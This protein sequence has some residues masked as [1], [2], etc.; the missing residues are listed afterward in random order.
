MSDDSDQ[1]LVGGR[2]VSD[3]KVVEL[4]KE[5]EIRSLPKSGNKK[6]LVERLEHF[7]REENA[8]QT[9]Q[10][11]QLQQPS[12]TT[13]LKQQ[14]S[15]PSKSPVAVLPPVVA[16]YLAQQQIQL[17][18][19]RRSADQ[20][21]AGTSLTESTI[22]GQISSPTPADIEEQ[23]EEANQE[24][25]QKGSE[26]VL[27]EPIP[28]PVV[29]KA[30][31]VEKL[32]EPEI[33]KG[34]GPMA[35]AVKSVDEIKRD[36]TEKEEASDES[37]SENGVEVAGKEQ[38]EET[39][40]VEKYDE[41]ATEPIQDE[42]EPSSHVEEY[43][44]QSRPAD[45]AVGVTA[46]EKTVPETDRSA[47][48]V[49]N[50][51]KLDTFADKLSPHKSAKTRSGIG[52]DE[53][54]FENEEEDEEEREE[55]ADDGG[56]RRAHLLQGS[57]MAIASGEEQHKIT[58][59]NAAEEV[60]GGISASAIVAEST[61]VGEVVPTIDQMT[62]LIKEESSKPPE[63]QQEITPEGFIRRR[64]SSP[65]RNPPS[66]WIHIRNLKR[67]F[68][69]M[70]L[71]DLLGKFGTIDTTHFWMDSIKS[72]CIATYEAEEQAQLSR[73][74]LH[75][76]VWPAASDLALCVEYSTE[77]KLKRRK[78]EEEREASANNSAL[79]GGLG[80]TIVVD[81]RGRGAE[82]VPGSDPT[83]LI[84]H[85]K[86]RQ[87][88]MENRKRKVEELEKSQKTL[89]ELFKK[90]K[91]LPSIYFLPLSDEEVT[92]RRKHSSGGKQQQLPSQLHG[93]SDSHRRSGGSAFRH[94]QS[95]GGGSSR[96]SG[97]EG[98]G[99]H[100]PSRR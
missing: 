92:K 67:P 27:K 5:L 73:E 39:Q 9:T 37:S 64:A 50:E 16:Q 24:L 97:G 56:K 3:L 99:G 53:L 79:G 55:P 88:E 32:H 1:L 65:A 33:V 4:R 76:V 42:E 43:P 2:P 91:T 34:S 18:A 81:N 100:R 51:A 38:G 28:T 90:T 17:Q 71:F 30:S 69:K 74:R 61:R 47:E 75:N 41:Q 20:M 46:I 48:N 85:D 96:R 23:K 59:E 26:S 22:I 6:E 40:E 66:R 98:G 44:K 49:K 87:K 95:A 10:E 7:L 57:P 11:H 70:A 78:A 14:S 36:A 52:E 83:V 35:E 13:E 60:V 63:G 89:D 84:Q 62:A 54:D 45:A 19:A 93:S 77:E 31:S 29:E 58:L 12:P 82:P 21:R 86:E 68:T 80:L 15:S 94:R 72:T 8:D 25:P